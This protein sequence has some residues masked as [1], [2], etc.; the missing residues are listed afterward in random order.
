[1]TML[2]YAGEQVRRFDHD[3]FMTTIFAPP[4]SREHL[5]ALY[6]FNIEIAKVGEIVSEPLIGKMR[7]QWWRDALDR[8]HAGERVAHAVAEPLGVAIAACRLP[9]APLDRLIDAREFDLEQTPPVDMAAFERY[10]DD[11]GAPLIELAL[12]M[13]GHDG[14]I[15]VE[16]A[17]LTGMAWAMTGLLRA[18]PFHARH[19]RCYLPRD[20]MDALGIRPGRLFDLKPEA[21]LPTLVEEIAARAL[22]CLAEARRH[23][24]GVPR[25]DRSPLLPMTLARLYLGD[26]K[27]AGWD[28]FALERQP[29]RRFQVISLA[30]GAML[31]RY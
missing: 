21:E 24:A 20:R 16:A 26:L 18:I 10:A 15:A 12:A 1:M 30:F 6:A 25:A 22:S 29:P 4:A 19:R 14:L 27:R 2:S 11:T 8:L 17:R 23:V 13:L 31:G 3:R 5:L 9:R 7:L 28:P